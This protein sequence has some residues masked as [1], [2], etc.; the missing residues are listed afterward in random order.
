[1]MQTTNAGK[2]ALGLLDIEAD[3]AAM[4]KEI[5]VKTLHIYPDLPRVCVIVP[6]NRV[7][8]IS[9]S[10][11]LPAALAKTV[12]NNEAIITPVL[13]IPSLNLLFA[14]LTTS[15]FFSLF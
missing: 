14:F 4:I 9:P 13:T 2:N 15:T 1:M 10:I 11:V 12:V 8:V 3:I 5:A 6:S 7:F